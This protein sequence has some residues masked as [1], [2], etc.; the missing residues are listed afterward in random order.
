MKEISNKDVDIIGILFVLFSFQDSICVSFGNQEFTEMTKLWANKCC[1]GIL[2]YLIPFNTPSYFVFRGRRDNFWHRNS[3][4]L[5]LLLLTIHIAWIISFQ[6]CNTTVILVV[7]FM[8]ERVC[9]LLNNS[10]PLPEI[11]AGIRYFDSLLRMMFSCLIEFGYCCS[12]S[13]KKKNRWN[14]IHYRDSHLP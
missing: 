6:I 7:I 1:S 5:F 2:S 9:I 12:Y 13:M 4:F 14:F 10:I 11:K 3:F 8:T